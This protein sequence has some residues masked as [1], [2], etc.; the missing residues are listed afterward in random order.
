MQNF[1]PHAP[2]TL[3]FDIILHII[4]ACLLYSFSG[5]TPSQLVM[6]SFPTTRNLIIL[7]S[8]L[9]TRLDGPF[10]WSSSVPSPDSVPESSFSSSLEFSEL[11]EK[12][13]K[14]RQSNGISSKFTKNNEL[15]IREIYFYPLVNSPD[16]ISLLQTQ[17]SRNN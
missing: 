10:S 13:S 17:L 16:I 3:S 6:I 11:Q 7:V 12:P 5:V 1:P 4:I 15:V 8:S 14:S 9:S 2:L